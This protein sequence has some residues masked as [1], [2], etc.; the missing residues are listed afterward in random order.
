MLSTNAMK[1]LQPLKK[2]GDTKVEKEDKEL[3]KA[4]RDFESLL[5]NQLL[6]KMRET[7]TKTD[8]FGS[9]EKEEMFQGMLDQETSKQIA[10]TGAFGIG[11]AI[12]AQFSR[13]IH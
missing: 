9:R 4:C 10:Q 7:I 1:G 13:K 3:R 5:V 2:T 12:Y 6:S 8:L 11:D